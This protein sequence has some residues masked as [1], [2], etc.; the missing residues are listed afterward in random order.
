[1]L[2]PQLHCVVTGGG[3]TKEGQWCP[4]RHGVLLPVRGVMPVF[5]GKRRHASRRAVRQ[6]QLE[7]PEGMSSQRLVNRLNK[8]GRQQWHVPMRER[9]PHGTGV[10]IDLAR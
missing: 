8:L 5:R 6:G 1:V 9:S 10:L 4:V 2:H 7:R 3:V